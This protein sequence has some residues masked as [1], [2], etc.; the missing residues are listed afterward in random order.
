MAR[1]TEE[2]AYELATRHLEDQLYTLTDKEY[3]ALHD[4][5]TEFWLDFIWDLLVD[6]T[7]P[8][9]VL[10]SDTAAEDIV[11]LGLYR[12]LEE[13]EPASGF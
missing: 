10:H 11:K 13:I 4:G 7:L 8:I 12:A 3:E 2:V 5:A 6:G 9:E 1:R